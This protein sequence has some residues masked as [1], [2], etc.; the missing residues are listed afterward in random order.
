MSSVF[1]ITSQTKE[2][3]WIDAAAVSI[4]EV[5][6]HIGGYYVL[7]FYDGLE[8]LPK[9]VIEYPEHESTSTC[10]KLFTHGITYTL[11]FTNEEI[12]QKHCSVTVYYHKKLPPAIAPLS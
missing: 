6:I 4:E 8:E 7:S 10:D 11:I 1:H 9:H 5:K 3:A 12:P 2:R